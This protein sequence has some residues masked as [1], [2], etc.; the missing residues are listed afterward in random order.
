MPFKSKAQQRFMFAAESRGEVPKGTAR[1]WAHHTPDIKSL[2]E[3]KHTKKAMLYVL[4]SKLQKRAALQKITDHLAKRADANAAPQTP[5]TGPMQPMQ[6]GQPSSVAMAP[7]KSDDIAKNISQF[8]STHRGRAAYERLAQYRRGA[9]R[10][11]AAASQPDAKKRF[12]QALG[13]SGEV[14][15]KECP[16]SKLRSKGK[17]RGLGFGK[18]KGPIGVPI[19]EKEA[20]SD[21]R[22]GTPFMDGFI[23]ACIERDLSGEQMADILEKA[24]ECSGTL[25]DEAR[26]MIDRMLKL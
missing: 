25:G 10:G 7:R 11:Y 15:D 16:G 4:V 9:V 13:K 14:T 20:G 12:Q 22:I 18:G 21:Q 17:G 1:R 2:P 3:K 26:G 19:V 8:G 6:A 23:R 5:Q 24:A